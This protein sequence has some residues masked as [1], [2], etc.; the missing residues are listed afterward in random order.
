MMLQARL[1]AA[2]QLGPLMALFRQL[3]QLRHVTPRQPQPK[4]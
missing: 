3:Q 2:E 1:R 4:E